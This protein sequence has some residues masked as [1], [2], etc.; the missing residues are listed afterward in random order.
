LATLTLACV[1]ACVERLPRVAVIPPV[2]AASTVSS[3]TGCGIG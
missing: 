3:E 1:E 2:F